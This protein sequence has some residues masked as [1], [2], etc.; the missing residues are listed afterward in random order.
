MN[1]AAV[2]G[3]R[4]DSCHN[5]SYASQGTKGALGSGSYAG[6]VATA[7]RDCGT[8]HTKAAP[9]FTTWAGATYAH[10]A[11][12]TNCANCHNGTTA[13][14]KTTP[15]HIPVAASVQCS[16]C[17]SNT[18]SS[19]ATYTMNH[20]AVS[21]VR[22]DSCHN[23]SYASQGTKGALGSGSY[24]G[25]VATA[26]RDCGTCHTKAAPG[27]TTWAGATYAHAAGD[28]NC[29]NCH[30][31]TT[32][33][34]KTTPPHIP[35]AASVQC[36]NCHSNTASSFATYTMNHAAVSGVRCDSCHNG[37]YASQGT[38]GAL[39]SGSYAGHVATA[40]RIVRNLPTRRRERRLHD[41]GGRNVRACGRRHQLRELPQ[42][43]DGDRQD[44][45]AAYSGGGER[46]MFELP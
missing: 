3:V 7:G 27:F 17:H 40:A 31:G 2:S 10:A 37:S 15:P 4:C 18:A 1:H 5:G 19:F 22:C 43:H 46:A 20:A 11:G 24:A 16:N 45:A 14:G 33:T 23:G 12:D 44:D 21:G 30:N 39:G 25:H 13:T 8:C 6:H 26:G 38:K 36:S 34:G 35:V 28:T 41:M 29:A 32:A 9:G 42:R